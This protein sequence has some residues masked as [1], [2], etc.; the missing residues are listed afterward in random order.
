MDDIKIGR[1]VLTAAGVQKLMRIT[2][3]TEAQVRAAAERQGFDVE[4][5]PASPPMGMYL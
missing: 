2:G 3:E 5:L 1:P 4:D